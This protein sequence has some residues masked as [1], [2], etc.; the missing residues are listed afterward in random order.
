M[1]QHTVEKLLD[2]EA[3][4][5]TLFSSGYIYDEGG[6]TRKTGVRQKAEERGKGRISEYAEEPR[7]RVHGRDQPRLQ[8]TWAHE[9]ECAP[10]ATQ[11]E[12]NHHDAANLLAGG[13][14]S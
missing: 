5:V 8:P 14:S 10:A 9:A 12:I 7:G 4:P 2:M 6:I 13:V 1:A 11:N 3:T